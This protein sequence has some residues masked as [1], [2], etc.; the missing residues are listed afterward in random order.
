M[1]GETLGDHLKKM[2]T[3]ELK[4]KVFSADIDILRY[5]ED[6][7]SNFIDLLSFRI[8]EK[9]LVNGRFLGLDD[10]TAEDLTEMV[11]N[12]TNDFL[13]VSK[14]REY[15]MPARLER[16]KAYEKRAGVPKNEK[17]KQK[18]RNVEG[19]IFYCTFWSREGLFET[20]NSRCRSMGCDVYVVEMIGKDGGNMGP[21]DFPG[22]C[23]YCT[24][25]RKVAQDA[26]I[27]HQLNKM[28]RMQNY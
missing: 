28:R 7:R 13:G 17:R 21:K 12:I 14:E 1:A 4:K 23:D 16:K 24:T 9:N 8:Y 15:V 27:E 26:V 20:N 3:H 19:K 18:E 25:S 6:R 5:D 2:I 10:I 11:R 22:M